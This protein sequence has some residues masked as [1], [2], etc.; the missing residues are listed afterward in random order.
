MSRPELAGTQPPLLF[1]AYRFTVRRA[2]SQP[3]IHLP[4]SLPDLNAPVYGS[5]RSSPW[6]CSTRHARGHPSCPSACLR[7]DCCATFTR[8]YTSPAIRQ[9]TRTC[10]RA[11]PRALSRDAAAHPDA[12]RPASGYSS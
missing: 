10:S 5:D 3:A 4:E 6:S 9:S 8:A 11:R 12:T 2:P 7:A 1:P